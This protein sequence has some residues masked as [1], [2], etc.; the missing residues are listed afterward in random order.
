MPV[1]AALT[2]QTGQNKTPLGKAVKAKAV[3]SLQ[4]TPV[5][6]F[7]K[8]AKGMERDTQY[9]IPPIDWYWIRVVTL[10]APLSSLYS[11]PSISIRKC[12]FT[13]VNALSCN[14]LVILIRN[15]V[16]YS[17]WYSDN[18]DHDTWRDYN[19]NENRK[20]SWQKSE[21]CE[22]QNGMILVQAKRKSI[23]WEVLQS[24]RCDENIFESKLSTTLFCIGN[25][26]I[27]HRPLPF[28]PVTRVLDGSRMANTYPANASAQ[29]ANAFPYIGMFV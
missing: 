1:K 13:E 24:V 29:S 20:S 21:K 3:N 2:P 16:L 22:S 9:Y 26:Y 5:N 25:G 7:S 8:A 28:V 18:I 19:N 14:H 6:P 10:I 23:L 27:H 11:K 15:F 4:A 12:L 17:C